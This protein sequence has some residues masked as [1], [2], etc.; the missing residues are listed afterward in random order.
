MRFP[1]RLLV[2]NMFFAVLLWLAAL[3]VT[4]AI[5]AAVAVFGDLDQSA[6]EKVPQIA[7]WY[8]L[9]TGVALIREFLPMYIAHGQTRREFGG[10]A[11][12]TALLFAP[13]LGVLFALGYLIERGVYALAGLPPVLGRGHLYADTLQFPVVVAEHTLQFAVWLAAGTFL[14]A[15]YYRWAGGGVLACLPV[16]AGLVLLAE[17]TV[18]GDLR[19][20]FANRFG[21]GLDL[22]WPA[23]VL[24]G[25]GVAT[26]LAGLALTWP[27][28]R[29]VPLRTT[30]A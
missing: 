6:W 28:I 15:A 26:V 1:S 19:L 12:V 13:F 17:S 2:A 8:A 27:I 11:L 20:P 16:A 14:G 4:A 23:A 3:A 7:R 29:D 25:T 22:A 30:R 10:H 18:G 9:F 5:A 24:A 21:L